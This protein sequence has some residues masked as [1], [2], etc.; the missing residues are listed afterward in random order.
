MADL[1]GFIRSYYLLFS[2]E[3]EDLEMLTKLSFAIEDS[4][5]LTEVRFDDFNLLV[6][7]SGVGKTRILE[8]LRIAFRSV[9]FGAEFA[10]GC[11]WEIEYKRLESLYSWTAV[12]SQHNKYGFPEA[13][14][15]KE[16]IKKDGNEILVRDDEHSIFT[17]EGKK[18]PRLNNKQSAVALLQYD[19]NISPLFESIRNLVSSN[20][21]DLES[22]HWIKTD[23]ISSLDNIV[24][25]EVE[26]EEL[27]QMSDVP[28]LIRIFVLQNSFPD[29]FEAL[30]EQFKEIFPIISSVKINSYY[31]NAS[32]IETSLHS[33]SLAIKETG[34]E[35]VSGTNISSGMA[36][37]FLLLAEVALAPTDSL[38]VID[39][40]ENS[41]GLN[42]LSEVVDHLL[43]Q[44]NLQFI[45]TSHHPYIINNIPMKYWKLV[46]RK[47]SVVT[48][49]GANS[50]KGLDPNSLHSGFVQLTNLE[51]YEEAIG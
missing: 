48:V 36:K 41:L 28:L 45:I 32:L 27:C 40:I 21:S 6:G 16:T 29:K 30:V 49:K 1:V 17:L 24:G 51:E 33:L 44:S 26:F 47:G 12:I 42:C 35:Y 10:A 25:Y 8:A 34:I 18:L 23:D 22:T 11:S 9:E 50:M 13:V 2:F 39:E 37:T 4:W 20:A 7:K 46:T 38:I 19:Y 15:R 14:F 5:K 31:S 3:L 43:R